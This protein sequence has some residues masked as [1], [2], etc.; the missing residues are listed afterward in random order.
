MT[1]NDSCLR[2][3]YRENMHDE[4]TVLLYGPSIYILKSKL[5][6]LKTKVMIKAAKVRGDLPGLELWLKPGSR[7]S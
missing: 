1:A 2:F 7:Y 3:T 5:E 4:S 6:E